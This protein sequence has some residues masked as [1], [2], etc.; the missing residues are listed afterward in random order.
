VAFLVLKYGRSAA[1]TKGDGKAIRTRPGVA[2]SGNLPI[3][4]RDRW[5]RCAQAIAIGQNNAAG[6]CFPSLGMT[7]WASPAAGS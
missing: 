3:G 7:V 2:R 4:G 5:K 6:N 1:N